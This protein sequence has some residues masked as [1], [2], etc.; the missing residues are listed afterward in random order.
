MLNNRSIVDAI[1]NAHRDRPYCE[2]GRDTVTVYR[3]GAMWLECAVINEPLGN[4]VSR[5]WNVMTDP[6]HVHQLIA[7]LPAPEYQ[8]A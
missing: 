8:A 6:G 2:C 1:E 5:I 7:E 4:R 3:A